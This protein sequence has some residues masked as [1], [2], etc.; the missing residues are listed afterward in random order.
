MDLEERVF[1]TARIAD[2]RGYSL[3]LSRLSSQLIGGPADPA[4]VERAV[5]S[6]GRLSMRDGYVGIE[7]RVRSVECLAR[8]A[9]D[10]ELRTIYRR[11]ASEF[12]AELTSKHPEVRLIM[13]GGS[14]S[15]NGLCEGEDIDFDIVVADGR[16]YSTYLHALYLGMRYSIRHRKLTVDRYLGI[17]PKLICVNVVWE[18]TQVTPFM[19][20][21]EQMAFEIVNTE[22]IVGKDFYERMIAT[23]PWIMD[24]FPQATPKGQ[25]RIE[26][27]PGP[28][29]VS[30]KE[31][32]A[33]WAVF[34]L[35]RLVRLSRSF[36]ADKKAKMDR[37]ES[38]KSPYG[39]FDIPSTEAI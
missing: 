2:E 8:S 13:V 20:R 29:H 28:I 9:P 24:I 26:K 37:A 25:D 39:I 35:F 7:G 19:R 23:N 33:R 32:S 11:I 22:V 17:V 30:F 18:E 21:D 27:T 34:T 12:S 3:S 15:S 1:R 14:T 38:V 4:E 36:D 5:R 31:R 10:K 16:K 6:S